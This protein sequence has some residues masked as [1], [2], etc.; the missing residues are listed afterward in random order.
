[1][2]AVILPV[3]EIENFKPLTN[4]TPEYLL[5]ITNK[6]IIEHQIEYLV[7][8]GIK[9]IIIVIKHMPFETERYLGDGRRWGCNINYSLIK[10]YSGIASSLQ[11]FPSKLRED[12]LCLPGNL[13][14]NLDLAKCFEIFNRDRFDVFIFKNNLQSS[15]NLSY[16]RNEAK[17]TF[18]PLIMS[19]L[20]L[21]LLLKYS[22]K[23]TGHGD[24]NLKKIKGMRVKPY[25]LSFQYI[26]ISDLNDYHQA[27]FSILNNQFNL[28]FLPGREIR[29]SVR[30]GNH[31]NIHKSVQL[32]AN[33]LIG[34]NCRIKSGVQLNK[35]SIIGDNVLIDSDTVIDNSIV[36]S[37][38]YIGSNMEIANAVVEKNMLFQIPQSLHVFI[39][40][41]FI[42]GDMDK[43]FLFKKI[44]R[45]YNRSLGLLLLI[46]F[47]PLITFL[48]LYH[49]MNKSNKYFQSLKRFGA[50]RIVDLNGTRQ[51]TIFR[52]YAFSSPNRFIS[53]LPGL[54]NVVLGDLT[55]VGN[56]P[57]DEQE[58][59]KE[60]EEWEM[61]RHEAPVGLFHIWEAEGT[62]DM[63]REE[64]SIAESYYAINRSVW[65]DIKILFKS[66]IIWPYQNTKNGF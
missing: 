49:L 62:T 53:K 18:F 45:F 11:N 30:I 19:P 42:L 33:T 37:N 46:L 3:L 57:L 47:S 15:N 55:L 41:D 54:I 5:K 28:V 38:T 10:E 25:G 6:T 51:P 24:N 60:K 52:L 22:N 21:D 35:N 36:L 12:F 65:G 61:P 23:N 40:D 31:T 29:P 59:L 13:L 64:K 26:S 50:Y 27:N 43:T 34:D 63:S 2:K 58:V 56:S 44:E 8:Y 16:S 1:M 17:D 39:A 20:G 48:F 14:L 4:W 7:S 9:E 66:I 32:A